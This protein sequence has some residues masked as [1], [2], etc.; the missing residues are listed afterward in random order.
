MI[1]SVGYL[2]SSIKFLELFIEHNNL[3]FAKKT[4]EDRFIVCSLDKILQ[5]GVNCHWLNSIGGDKYQLSS[6]G[7][8]IN[9]M[10]LY[11]DKMRH[12]LKD[13]IQSYKPTWSRAIYY[14]R[15][16]FCKIAPPDIVQC[17]QE[18]ELL[19]EK[20]DENI[21]K[22][23][24]DISSIF[25]GY[26]N[27]ILYDIGRRGELLTIEYEYNRTGFCPKWQSFES[28]FSGY[29]ILSIISNNNKTPLCIEVK[30]SENRIQD[31]SMTITSNEWNQAINSTN[32]KFYL[33]SLK[34]KPKLAII[35]YTDVMNHIPDDNG[36]G[37][38]TSANIPY[39]I[40]KDVFTCL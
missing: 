38:W 5:L 15:Q 26:K 14:G 36:K 29:D 23:W 2:H 4:R 11:E 35:E 1:I 31:A 22:W 6:R 25:R 37:K 8:E 13:Y 30:S 39:R 17:L 21:I 32:Y 24:D 7:I 28:N 34:D 3:K 33:W 27:K 20:P 12:L 18:S 19:V 10:N 40:F 9:H 16:E